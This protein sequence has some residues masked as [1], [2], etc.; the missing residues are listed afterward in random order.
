MIASWEIQKAVFTA[1]TTPTQI[2]G[3]VFDED[4]RTSGTATSPPY[5]VIGET[6]ERPWDTHDSDGSEEEITLHTWSRMKGSSEVKQIMAA[7]D[8]RLHDV[9][10]TLSSGAMVGGFQRTFSQVLRE[11]QASGETWR[12]GIVRYMARIT[13]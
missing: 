6:V 13:V 3:A 5:T 12:H 8:T 2:T 11:Q 10:L 7:I 4:P 1:L 9:K